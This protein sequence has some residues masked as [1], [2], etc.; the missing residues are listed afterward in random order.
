MSYLFYY[1]NSNVQMYSTRVSVFKRCTLRRHG[2]NAHRFMLKPDYTCMCDC[3]SQGL[4]CVPSK[5]Y[6]IIVLNC[7]PRKLYAIKVLNCVARKLYTIKVL[8]R[9]AR[10]LY[11]TEINRKS[12]HS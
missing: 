8:N 4:Y 3:W 11:I 12:V 9:F 2:Q 6:A 1:C 7:V 10:N 5:L